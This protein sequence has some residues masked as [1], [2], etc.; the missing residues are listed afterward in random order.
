ME[1]ICN[2]IKNEIFSNQSKEQTYSEGIQQIKLSELHI[3]KNE[4]NTYHKDIKGININELIDYFNQSKDYEDKFY[5]KGNYKQLSL[6]NFMRLISQRLIPYLYI[7][8]IIEYSIELKKKTIKLL[9]IIIENNKNVF[10]EKE[11]LYLINNAYEYNYNQNIFNL[12]ILNISIDSDYLLQLIKKNEMYTFN[13]E[14]ITVLNK[15]IHESKEVKFG[16]IDFINTENYIA[17]IKKIINDK[18]FNSFNKILLEK[19]K[20]ITLNDIESSEIES[21]RINLDFIKKIQNSGNII[22]ERIDI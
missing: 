19:K 22:Q 1:F 16:W 13:K 12:L 18:E 17:Y 5:R 20:N 10:T 7:I 14:E 3:L 21:S 11:V 8:P 4:D 9:K 2:K 15:T 6:D